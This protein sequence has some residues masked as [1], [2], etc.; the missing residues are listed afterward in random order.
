MAGLRLAGAAFA[1]NEQIHLWNAAGLHEWLN[2]A[3]LA[4]GCQ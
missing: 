2:R 1:D 3:D 4:T